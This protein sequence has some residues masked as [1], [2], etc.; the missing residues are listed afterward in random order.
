MYRLKHSDGEYLVCLGGF[1][2]VTQGN[3]VKIEK[4]TKG[5]IV[6]YHL[7]RRG[8]MR[9]Y[10]CWSRHG[11][12]LVDRDEVVEDNDDSNNVTY[13]NLYG[14]L[15]DCEDDVV[16]EDYENFQNLFYDSNKNIGVLKGYVRNQ[17]R[18]EGSIIEGYATEDVIEY[19]TDYLQCDTSIG[20][21]RSRHEGRLIG[22]VTLGLKKVN[23]L[24][25]T[26]SG[27]QFG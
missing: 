17:Y 6:E 3:R 15:Q 21:P 4:A 11:K 1:L 8:F 7:I 22:H 5:V 14:M 20:V 19:C 23:H 12:T 10:T 16:E 25:T 9:G 24:L 27:N 26:I 13:D 2:R 18:P